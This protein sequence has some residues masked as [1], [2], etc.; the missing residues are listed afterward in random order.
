MNMKTEL[1]RQIIR[2]EVRRTIAQKRRLNENLNYTIKSLTDVD[3]EDISYD[4]I[5]SD[6]NPEGGWIE[7]A[8]FVPG[9]NGGRELTDDELEIIND[10]YETTMELINAKRV[11]MRNRK[12]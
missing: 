11:G 2:E 10:D 6:G 3:T 9:V 1:L 8:S 12:I 4:S 7:S 5:V